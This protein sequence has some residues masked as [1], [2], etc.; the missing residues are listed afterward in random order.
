MTVLS[1]TLHYLGKQSQCCGANVKPALRRLRAM[2]DPLSVT[3][4]FLAPVL[5][6]RVGLNY[7]LQYAEQHLVIMH[8]EYTTQLT[9][10]FACS[11]RF[12]VLVTMVLYRLC[13][14]MVCAVGTPWVRSRRHRRLRQ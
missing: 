10:A 6:H 12:V 5:I 1:C 3:R 4:G 7:M 8:S 13:C 14:T 11:P 2:M 9:S